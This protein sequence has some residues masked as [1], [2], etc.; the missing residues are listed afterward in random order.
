MKTFLRYSADEIAWCLT[1]SHNLSK[2]RCV[3]HRLRLWATCAAR[4]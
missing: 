1:C 4:R 2:V 3:S